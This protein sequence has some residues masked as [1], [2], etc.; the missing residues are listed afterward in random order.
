MVSLMQGWLIMKCR[1]KLGQTWSN[2]INLDQ[3]WSN[4]IKLDQTW[5]NLI[6]LDQT[7]SNLKILIKLDQT[8]SNWLQLDTT[9]T[10]WIKLDQ[11]ASNLNK[12][13]QTG[14]NSINFDLWPRM[15]S[16]GKFDEI[17]R[18]VWLSGLVRNHQV[19]QDQKVKCDHQVQSTIN[20][21]PH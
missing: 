13:D 4:L 2:L 17:L 7:W 3:S 14:P 1:T 15:A 9:G 21:F 16:L 11:I 6:N 18:K 10:N 8:G 19:K 12:L 20:F 5:S